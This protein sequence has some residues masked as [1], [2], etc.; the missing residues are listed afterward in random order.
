MRVE[1]VEDLVDQAC[2][3]ETA[4]SRRAAQRRVERQA[5]G[6]VGRVARLRTHD[7]LKEFDEFSSGDGG[8]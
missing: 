5:G 1:G 4:H 3:F 6:I 7:A 2:G 8:S